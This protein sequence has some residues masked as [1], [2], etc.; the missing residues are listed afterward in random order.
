MDMSMVEILG[1]AA[2]IMVAVSLTMID[3]VRLRVLNFIGCAQFTAY[4]LM[5]DAKPVVVTNVFIA[6]V[7]VNFWWKCNRKSRTRLRARLSFP[8]IMPGLSGIIFMKKEN[9]MEREN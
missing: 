1:Y 7:N 2:S 4:G 3:N 5:I 8:E 6:C 9:F